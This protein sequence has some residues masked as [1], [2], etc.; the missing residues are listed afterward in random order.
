MEEGHAVAALMDSSERGA[1]M[2]V[3]MD[4]GPEGVAE[5]WNTGTQMSTLLPRRLLMLAASAPKRG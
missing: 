4:R 2:M 1:S 5:S 3:V